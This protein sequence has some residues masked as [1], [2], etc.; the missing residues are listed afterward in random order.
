MPLWGMVL[1]ALAEIRIGRVRVALSM[2]CVAIGV[3]VVT[4]VI[5]FSGL[6]QQAA[7]QIFEQQVGR[8]VTLTVSPQQNGPPHMT[9][10]QVDQVRADLRRYHIVGSPLRQASEVSFRRNG[11]VITSNGEGDGPPV[12]TVGADSS[13]SEIRRL[14]LL[15]GRWLTAQDDLRMEPSLVVDKGFAAKIGL[16]EATALGADLEI[17]AGQVWVKAR[18]VGVIGGGLNFGQ[19]T[20]YMPFQAMVRWKLGEDMTEF[21]VRV[22]PADA[23]R[24][25][26]QLKADSTKAW[27]MTSA[28]DIRRDSG[29]FSGIRGTL[30]KLILAAAVAVLMLGSLPVLALGLAAVRQRRSEFGVH[31]CF[32]ATGP[33]LFLT[34]LVESL[35]VSIA[36]GIIGTLL[37]YLG[38][39]AALSVLHDRGP[40]GQGAQIDTSFPWSAALLGLGVAICVG[41]FTGLIPA[42]RAMQRSV[43]RAIRS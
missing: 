9:E 22:Q 35:I 4:L 42:L 13:L 39:K 37:A 32:G 27:G 12:Q 6:V 3:A 34:V 2:I 30:G 20:V 29:D 33:D 14:T 28:P 19:P 1:S 31:R 43:I 8:P 17:G 36:G 21:A 38:Q 10:T 23:A 41:L 26:R 5:V 15:H 40:F 11:R 16:T 7:Q 25:T 24:V 18:I